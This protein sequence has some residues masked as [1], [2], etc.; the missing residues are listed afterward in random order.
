M[1]RRPVLSSRFGIAAMLFAAISSCSLL[2]GCVDGNDA[3]PSTE[4]A[5]GTGALLPGETVTDGL[6]R[7][8]DACMDAW[9][10]TFT[11]TSGITNGKPDQNRVYSPNPVSQQRQRDCTAKAMSVVGITPLT[12]AQLHQ[13]YSHQYRLVRCLLDLGYDMGTPVSEDAYV[14]AA[15]VIDP[16]SK[17][18]D[19]GTMDQPHAADDYSH[20]GE[21][22]SRGDA[23]GG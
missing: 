19:F 17:F 2:A 10:E 7:L 23:A 15:G 16:S 21:V 5:S 20:C 8:A 6:E 22:A 18:S 11:M 1:A 9:H 14:A 3:T 13:N 12:S 4:S